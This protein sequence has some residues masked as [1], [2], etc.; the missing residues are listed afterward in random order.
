MPTPGGRKPACGAECPP[1]SPKAAHP[2]SRRGAPVPLNAGGGARE[3]LSVRVIRGKETRS[4]SCDANDHVWQRAT[5]DGTKR[6][7]GR[8]GLTGTGTA[9]HLPR[10]RCARPVRTRGTRAGRGTA[11]RLGGTRRRLSR[12]PSRPPRRRQV[13]GSALARWG[14]CAAGLTCASA[15]GA[16]A[17]G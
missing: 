2:G 4:A 17:G 12:S 10:C 8:R 15:H 16:A 3:S 9:P 5:A 11:A 7:G 1:R 13:G 14:R 6:G